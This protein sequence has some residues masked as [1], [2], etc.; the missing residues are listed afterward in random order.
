MY[1]HEETICC[2]QCGKIVAVMVVEDNISAICQNCSDKN[3]YEAERLRKIE[4]YIYN[5]TYKQ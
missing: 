5:H 4:K 3:F 1:I 2:V